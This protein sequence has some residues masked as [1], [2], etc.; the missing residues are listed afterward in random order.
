MVS[1]KELQRTY[2]EFI[3]PAPKKDQSKS[4]GWAV[5]LTCNECY[6]NTEEGSK[7]GLL[8][9]G[10]SLGIDDEPTLLAIERAH[11]RRFIKHGNPQSSISR[12]YAWIKR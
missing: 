1:S 2:K 12:F 4:I 6:Y 10:E 9:L 7:K 5:R 11:T 3:F 8:I